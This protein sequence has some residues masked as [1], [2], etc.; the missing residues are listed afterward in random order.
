MSIS[1]I[2]IP[3]GL[4]RSSL[5][6]FGT[7]VPLLK[8]DIELV[9]RVLDTLSLSNDVHVATDQ[10]LAALKPGSE[11]YSQLQEL[12]VTASIL[13]YPTISVWIPYW[14]KTPIVLLERLVM[15]LSEF[16]YSYTF[17]NS[18]D[19]SKTAAELY[20]VKKP[21]LEYIL[22]QINAKSN[23][24]NSNSENETMQNENNAPFGNL[25]NN[26]SARIR[27]RSQRKRAR[28]TKKNRNT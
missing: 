2:P 14:A 12:Y 21:L 3:K 11:L 4:T 8:E 15:Q 7:I 9:F 19:V 10:I 27:T 20:K 23:L 28:K 13:G 26:N 25:N 24:N 22:K 6:M 16:L 1:S 17:D 18:Y 5:S